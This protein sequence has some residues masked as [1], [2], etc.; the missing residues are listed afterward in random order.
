MRTA[1]LVCVLAT[2]IAAG[3]AFAAS[4]QATMSVSATVVARAVMSVEYQAP[5]LTIT[6]EDIVR[7]YVDVPAAS[8][9]TVRCN[10]PAG[11]VL[12]FQGRA[13]YFR[14]VRIAGLPTEAVVGGQG[15]WLPQPYRRVAG[16]MELSY[17]FILAE[18]ARPGTYGWPLALSAGLM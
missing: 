16:T 3:A 15:G 13:D 5:T 9:F 4:N 17:R 7:G 1:H 2:A 10:A 12:T 6:E 18:S 8:R 11:Y 14:Q